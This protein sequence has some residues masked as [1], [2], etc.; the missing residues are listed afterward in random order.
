M[1]LAGFPFA[2]KKLVVLLN[3]WTVGAA[4]P[5]CPLGGA[6]VTTNGMMAP[7]P[8]YSVVRPEWLSET[9][10]GLAALAEIPQGFTRFGSVTSALPG[11]SATRLCWMK[12]LAGA[13]ALAALTN[14]GISADTGIAIR[15]T[16][17]MVLVFTRFPFLNLNAT[18]R[19]VFLAWRFL[20]AT[21]IEITWD[22]V[23]F[24][25]IKSSCRSPRMW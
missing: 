25:K 21:W 18:K 22:R 17:A 1:K 9:Q 23:N 3:T 5:Y 13:G 4:G 7:D 6:M 10:N 12:A 16:R 20:L 14:S 11:V 8:L 24:D 2:N 15:K 19:P